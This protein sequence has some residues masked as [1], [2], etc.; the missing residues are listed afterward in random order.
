VSDVVSFVLVFALI[1]SSVG[2][3]TTFGLGTLQE[4]QRSERADAAE[5][6]FVVFTRGLDGVEDGSRPRYQGEFDLSEATLTVTDGATVNV[7]VTGTGYH[8]SVQLGA[9]QY[10]TG[11]VSFTYESGGVFRRDAGGRATVV[12]PSFDCDD[13]YATL[14]IVELR[15]T[16]PQG[17]G[18]SVASVEVR[19]ETATV[20]YP[21]VRGTNAATGMTVDTTSARWRLFFE[22][23]DDWTGTG[24]Y[25]CSADHVVVRHTLIGVELRA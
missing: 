3:V 25:D 16:G 10:R 15:T 2:L 8:E 13:D 14:S 1:I 19:R 23:S 12:Q 11:D 20:R 22:R 6:A 7:N 24:P 18:G 5:R 9:L 17:V 21:E 4:L